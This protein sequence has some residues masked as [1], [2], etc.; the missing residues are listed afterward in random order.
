MLAL[1]TNCKPL[2]SLVQFLIKKNNTGTGHTVNTFT[3]P[4]PLSMCAN[5]TLT[6]LNSHDFNLGYHKKCVMT[7]KPQPD[8][9]G[10]IKRAF[11]CS[12]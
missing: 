9:S 3:D 1:S 4:I 8:F 12:L 10:K 6:V 2:E 7:S 5:G 11:F